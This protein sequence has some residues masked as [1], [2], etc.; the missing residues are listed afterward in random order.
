MKTSAQASRQRGVSRKAHARRTR[1]LKAHGPLESNKISTFSDL[2]QIE[3]AQ[4]SSAIRWLVFR[5]R[6]S[7]G[8]TFPA[9]GRAVPRRMA[10]SDH[11]RF[12]TDESIFALS[13]GGGVSDGRAKLGRRVVPVVL[14]VI[15]EEV[16]VGM[17]Q[18][19]VAQ[20]L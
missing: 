5:A 14:L 19:A 7:C 11:A 13:G 2:L 17:R 3:A 1:R 16:S 12:A 20:L 8:N 4:P 9:T 18:P 10:P 15:A 6:R